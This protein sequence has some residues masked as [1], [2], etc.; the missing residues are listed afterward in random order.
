M[1]FQYPWVLLLAVAP[2][3]W[4]YWELPRTPRRLSL[5]LKALSFVAIL[6]ALSQPKLTLSETR[7]AVAV[8]VDTSA[9]VTQKDLAKASEIAATIQGAR[10]RHWTRILPFARSTRGLN[11]DEQA[12]LKYTSGEAGRGTDLEAAIREAVASLPEGMVPRVA[13]ISDGKENQGS[14]ARAAWQANMQGVP[15]D[16]FPLAGRPQPSLRVEGV[17][18]PA[19]A[20]TGEKFPVEVTLRSPRKTEATVELTAEGKSLGSS[21]VSVDEGVSQ[22]RLHTSLS[23]TGAVNL[24]GT[25]HSQELGD[26]RFE[27]AVTLRRPRILYVS[28]DPEGTE[29]HL[30]ATLAAAQFDVTRASKSSIPEDLNLFQI[31]LFNNW[32][33]ETVPEQRKNDLEKYVKQGGGL[34]V[35]GGERNRYVEN[36]KIEDALDRSL[37]AKLAPPRSPEGTCVVLIIDKSSSMEGRKMELAR[38]A[39]IGVIENLRPVDT[40]GVL[41]FDNSFQWAVPIR[42][43]EDRTLIK[44]LVAGI[45][46]DGGT[47]IAPALSEAF[48]KISVATGTFKHIVLLTDGISEEGDSIAL[49]KEASE[50]KVTISTVGLGQDVNRA[51][52]EKVAAFAKGKSYFLT[53]PAGLEQILLRDVMEHTGTTAVEKPLQPTVLHQSEILAGVGMDQAPP[54]KGYVKFIAKPTADTI[55]NMEKDPLLT[56]W[57]YGLGRSAVFASDAKARWG[58]NWVTWGGYDRFWSNLLRDLLPHAQAGE[59]SAEFDSANGELV[60]D[61]RLE[62]QIPEPKTVPAIF[63]IGPEGFQKAIEVKKVAAGAFRGRVALGTRKGLFRI[64]PLA[65][66]QAFPEIGYY[67]Q[68]DEMVDYGANELLLKQIAE[69]TGGRFNPKPSEVFDANGRSIASTL[70]L[71]PLLLALA[72]ALN[73]AELIIRKWKGILQSLSRTKVA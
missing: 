64:R 9:S 48:R 47:Q 65:E 14:V 2:L 50:K 30:F 40:V 26:A 39:A 41:I 62:R 32:D 53:D 51:Y 61:Y 25:V 66:S 58:A 43:A 63:V 35:I 56:R 8:L 37:P 72:V 10:G 36:K 42:R 17:S 70:R 59:A 23:T 44:R 19:Q 16:T 45:T 60:V 5:V 46:P 6:V 54:L 71:W 69:F 52:L 7:I 33:L 68:E 67:R 24:A 49:A 28:S 1:T 11:Q 27:Q 73:L 20:F 31:V 22:L 15:V 38:L 34:L 55:L 3:A 4:M 12:T 57:Q 13:L 21:T 29:S 18:F